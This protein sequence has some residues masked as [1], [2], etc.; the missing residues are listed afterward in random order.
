MAQERPS[1]EQ[2]LSNF[3]NALAGRALTM[4]EEELEAELREEGSSLEELNRRATRV[5]DEVS[6][7][8]RLG[9]LRAARAR[10][11]LRAAEWREGGAAIEVPPPGGCRAAVT[12]V[13]S[14]ATSAGS[15]RFSAQFRDLKEFSD[16]DFVSCYRQLVMLGAIDPEAVE[17]QG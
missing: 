8:Y 3:L 15:R 5:F 14:S 17:P 16:E 4:P 13:F 12:A 10:Y 2:K 6:K 7:D 9:E 1:D 11:E